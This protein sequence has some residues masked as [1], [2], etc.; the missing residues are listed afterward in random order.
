MLTVLMIVIIVFV[1]IASQ[2]MVQPETFVTKAKVFTLILW[3]ILLEALPFVLLGVIISSLIQLFVSEDT[4]LR[5]LPKQRSLRLIFASFLGLVFPVCECA[6]IPI[7]R[8][9]IRKGMPAGP[10]FAFM[11][12]TPI[13]NPIVILSTYN[14]FGAMPEM[15]LYRT[16]GGFLAALIIG[17]AVEKFGGDA[18]PKSIPAQ[19]E[20]TCSH[21]LHDRHD[22]SMADDANVHARLESRE[23]IRAEKS[24][25]G[26]VW[27]GIETVLAH[28][29]AELKSVGMYLI[30]GALIAAS[31]QMI[32]DQNLL[33]AIGGGRI[34]S[35]L[36]MMA[37][38]FVLSL[39]SE[40][41]AF[42]ASTFLLHFSGA[43]VLAF[44][45]T[46]PMVDIKNTLMLLGSFKRKFVVQLI[47]I[48]LSVCFV[49][50][51]LA[52]YVMGGRYA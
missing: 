45:L 25:F 51:L 32:V 14:A 41:D 6:I 31:M 13:V 23:G 34:A 7:T 40:A 29:S 52:S 33:S 4:L 37:L 50:A 3:S 2:I 16:V 21:C 47:G 49:L 36:V 18:T 24:R 20:T 48:I 11:I 5:I 38:A 9:L 10:A 30:I 19:A 46:G 22:H 8:A 15:A 42:V 43:S 12:A 44:L 1:A 17:A 39:C 28:T 26:G 35:I 27:R